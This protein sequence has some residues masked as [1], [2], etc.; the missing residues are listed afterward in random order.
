VQLSTDQVDIGVLHLDQGVWA[1]HQNDFE[2][3]LVEFDMALE[4]LDG[5]PYALFNRS[6]TLLA[7]GRYPEGWKDYRTCWQIFR[8][9]LTERGKQLYFYDRH[10]LWD[11]EPG[12]PV[13]ILH[14]AGFGDGIQMMRYVPMVRALASS[15]VLEM[16]QQLKRLASQ[17]APILDSDHA[18]GYVVPWFNLM[19]IFQETATTIPPPPYLRPDEA[20]A[21]R[22]ANRVGNGGRRRVGIC[23]STKF[24]GETE[25]LPARRPIPLAQ[26]LDLLPAGDCDL[27]SL[28]IQDGEEARARGVKTLELEDF[29]DVA[30]IM[31]LMDVVVS[32][33]TAAAHLA[34]AIGHPCANVLL[35]YAATWRWLHGNW[36][37]SMNLCKQLRPGDWVSAF[38]QVRWPTR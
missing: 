20:L 4:L 11:G 15:V 16:P 19:Q 30:A 6:L 18:E 22:W 3:A 27:Y 38:E 25:P 12:V 24:D 5:S 37:P 23:W 28:Q 21:A 35:P 17:L 29:A 1:F 2:T 32:I 9:E 10:P 34:G 31:S 33:D 26:F 36:Y 8:N 13:V 14:E 7:L